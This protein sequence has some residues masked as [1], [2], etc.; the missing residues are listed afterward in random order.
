MTHHYWIG[1][2]HK[3]H[4]SIGVKGG[5]AQLDH[6]K[7]SRLEKMKAGDWLIYYSPRLGFESR[8]PYQHFTA[9]GEIKT[10]DVYSHDM[11]KGFVPYRT[12]VD[13]RKCEIAPI[14]PLLEKLSF[15]EGKKNWGQQMRLG[16]FEI[17]KSDFD[18]IA[19]AMKV[20]IR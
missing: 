7:K 15:T 10:G 9:I 3:D 2:V 20:S 19:K 13:F 17:T 6:G 18:L 11:G 16:H 4:V 14:R 1:V 12:D 5:Y 8:E